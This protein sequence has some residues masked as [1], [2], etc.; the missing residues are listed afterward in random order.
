[1]SP[2]GP[3]KRLKKVT[4][5]SKHGKSP[6][7]RSQAFRDEELVEL[8]HMIDEL[9]CRKPPPGSIHKE[10]RKIMSEVAAHLSAK[11]GTSYTPN[12]VK[13]RFSDLKVREYHRLGAIRRKLC[14]GKIDGLNNGQTSLSS[15]LVSSSKEN[16]I[17]G[18]PDPNLIG[19]CN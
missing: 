12:Q 16:V 4:E 9:T 3:N 15:N 17:P 2:H 5:A 13:K 11:F 18:S 7:K 6:K 14:E 19:K 1:M 8:V 10:K